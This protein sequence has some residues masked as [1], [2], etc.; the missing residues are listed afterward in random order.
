VGL[1]RLLYNPYAAMPSIHMAYATLVGGGV[2]LATNRRWLRVAGVAYP[3]FVFLEIVATGNHF[4]LDALAGVAIATV[5]VAAQHWLAPGQPL[6]TPATIWG[7]IQVGT[8]SRPTSTHS[9]LVE[10]APHAMV[11]R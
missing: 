6:F 11:D 9:T 4:V 8:S 3:L 2:Y 1:L 10:A 5:A 7:T